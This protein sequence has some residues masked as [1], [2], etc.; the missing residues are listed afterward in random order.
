MWGIHVNEARKWGG[1]E[2]GL[3]YVGEVLKRNKTRRGA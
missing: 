2:A 3:K 1:Y